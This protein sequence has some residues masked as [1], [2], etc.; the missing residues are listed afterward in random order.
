MDAS[1]AS[2]TQLDELHSRAA[3]RRLQ[4]AEE[5]RALQQQL[6][7]AHSASAELQQQNQQLQE[8][9]GRLQQRLQA[10]TASYRANDVICI[11]L[12]DSISRLQQQLASSQATCQQQVHVGAG[13]VGHDLLSA[14]SILC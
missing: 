4:L 2:S 1:S 14:H 5:V 9:N 13:L 8:D 7:G 10:A 12:R 11:G 3:A 6:A